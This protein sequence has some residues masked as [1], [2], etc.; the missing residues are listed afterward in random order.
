MGSSL[1]QIMYVSLAKRED[2]KGKGR[3]EGRKKCLFRSV[4]AD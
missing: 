4:S 3:D 2:A 1:L